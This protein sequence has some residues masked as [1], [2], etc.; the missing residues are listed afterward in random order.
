MVSLF[1]IKNVH[2]A[3]RKGHAAK[4]QKKFELPALK[5]NISLHEVLQS[6]LIRWIGLFLTD[7]SQ[8]VQIGR[9]YSHPVTP[10]GDTTRNKTCAIA[11]RHISEQSGSG[12]IGLNTLMT[13]Q[14]MNLLLDVC[15]ATFHLSPQILTPTL[16]C[17]TCG[18]MRKN[19]KIWLS[20]FWSINPLL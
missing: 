8:R 2:L 15:L 20:I 9:V 16:P 17:V 7:C 3:K 14:Y 18:L 19:V 13:P 10:N 4:E 12:D 5:S 1:F 11:V 6:W